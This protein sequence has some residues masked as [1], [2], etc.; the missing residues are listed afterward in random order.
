M[1]GKISRISGPGA[2]SS[3]NVSGPEAEGT[4]V[5]QGAHVSEWR[6]AG[7]DP[8]L[9]MSCQSALQPGLPL[10]GGIPICFPWFAAHPQDSSLP[11]HGRVRTQIWDVTSCGDHE[12]GSPLIVLQTQC[13]D[14]ELICRV[15]L[16]K[17]LELDLKITLADS[18]ETACQ[19][20][21]A[22][23]TYLAVGDIRRVTV[24]GLEKSGFIDKVH[25]QKL[26]APENAPL[27]FRG[28]TD[29]IYL[30]TQSEVVVHDPV[31]NR[32]LQI[33]GRGAKSTVVWN[34]W[35]EKSARMGDFGDDEWTEML[36]VETA[37]V[38]RNQLRLEPGES[39]LLG[40]TISAAHV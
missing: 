30:D 11:L 25:D 2:H 8:V 1:Q 31:L 4:V 35:I 19:F 21:A 6:P 13:D 28:E 18:A 12:T 29:R 32:Q 38:N 27:K 24:S 22:L 26:C 16:A 17:S 33:R 15:T 37:C 5:L 40:V 9:W 39:H 23:H 14:F 34:P 3:L 10:R 20:E 7:H 36:C